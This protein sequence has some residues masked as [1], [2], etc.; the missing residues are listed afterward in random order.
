MIVPT[1]QGYNHILNITPWDPALR[2]KVYT[3]DPNLD[4][5]LAGGV[6]NTAAYVQEAANTWNKASAFTLQYIEGYNRDNVNISF[7]TAADLTNRGSNDCMVDDNRWGVACWNFDQN[8]NVIA[9]KTFF[10]NTNDVPMIYNNQ[11]LVQEANG[12]RDIDV[13]A[14]ALHELGHFLLLGDHPA[15]HPEA[16]MDFQRAYKPNLTNDDKQGATIFH[17]PYTSFEPNQAQGEPNNRA[18]Y[19]RAVTGYAGAPIPEMFSVPTDRGVAPQTGAWQQHI[20]GISTSS[21]SYVYF[22]AFSWEDDSTGDPLQNRTIAQITNTTW[23]H[24]CQVNY[25]QATMSIDFEMDNGAT[26]R[27]SG[28]SDSRGIRAHPAA[29]GVY[30]TTRF[31]RDIDLSAL[32]GRRIIRWFIAYDSGADNFDIQNQQFRAYFDDLNL[33]PFGLGAASVSWTGSGSVSSSPGAPYA[34]NSLVT[35]T[36]NPSP[37]W[38]FTGWRINGRQAGWANPLSKTMDE[39]TAV[40]ADFAQAPGFCDVGSNQRYYNAIVQMSARGIIRGANGCFNPS[41]PVLRAQVAAFIARALPSNIYIGQTW[42]SENWPNP[43]IDQ[44]GVDNNLWRNVATL[45]HYDVARGYPPN[46]NT[47][48]PTD[49]VLE[50]QAIAFISRAMVA[51]GYWAWQPDNSNLYTNVANEVAPQGTVVRRHGPP[52]VASGA[53]G[54]AA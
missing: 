26:L 9:A 46:Y 19:Q 44:N 10:N 11:G 43:F 42:D 51:K 14:L 1:A 3:I 21:Y 17:G 7:V 50:S 47:F 32:A 23:L 52:P 6:A 39:R 37:G 40:I 15:N 38:I 24:W 5:L 28:L 53:A 33:L 36:A 25:Q 16:V 13:Y 2:N 22:T 49:P 20:A 12:R 30:G 48:G 4:N 29:S 34:P 41:D 27:D 45:N 31:C 54:P 35:L 18:A 8:G